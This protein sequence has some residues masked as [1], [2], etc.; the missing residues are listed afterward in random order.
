[1][2]I[3]VAAALIVVHEMGHVLANRRLGGKFQGAVFRGLAVG[4]RLELPRGLRALALTSIAGPATEAILALL[5]LFAVAVHAL[6]AT[7]VPWTLGVLALDW[8]VNLMPVGAT[9]GARLLRVWRTHRARRAAV[10]S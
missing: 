3:I 7:V 8:A 5:L 10:A 9:D 2:G 4:V 1:M 6:P